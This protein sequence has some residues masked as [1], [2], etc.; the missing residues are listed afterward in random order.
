MVEVLPH[1]FLTGRCPFC[2]SLEVRILFSKQWVG[3][4][5]GLAVAGEA[6]VHAG[7]VLTA[8]AAEEEGVVD[9]LHIAVHHGC[10]GFP[11]ILSSL[12]VGSSSSFTD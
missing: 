10:D 6:E 12:L 3:S 7:T 1:C 2:N 8:F 5:F 11:L 9:A 4:W